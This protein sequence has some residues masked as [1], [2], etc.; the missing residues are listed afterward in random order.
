M[1]IRAYFSPSPKKTKRGS[2]GEPGP[3]GI[4][5]TI[6]EAPS[7]DMVRDEPATKRVK[8]AAAEEPLH[9][10]VRDPQVILSWNANSFISRCKSKHKDLAEFQALVRGKNPDLICISEARMKAHCDTK[11]A[12]VGSDHPRSRH[13]PRD[14]EMAEVSDALN[15]EPLRQYRVWWSLADG[16]QAGTMMLIHRRLGHVK[17]VNCLEVALDRCEQADPPMLNKHNRDGRIQYARFASFDVL[18]T[19]VPNRGWTQ[20]RCTTRQRWDDE[21]RH[22]LQARKKVT[23]KPLLWCGDLNVVHTP[24]DSTSEEFFRAE[25]PD[26]YRHGKRHVYENLMPARDRGIPGLPDSYILFFFLLCISN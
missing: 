2:Q 1:S 16:R 13:R 18:H 3:K 26:E 14:D 17:V 6:A 19:Y 5:V 25:V 23:S 11:T 4:K 22:F 24:A 9:D 7:H 20:E 12:K 8:L 10:E 21:I 15:T